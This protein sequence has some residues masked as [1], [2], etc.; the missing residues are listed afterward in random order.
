MGCARREDLDIRRFIAALAALA[1]IMATVSASP[2]VERFADWHRQNEFRAFGSSSS[3]DL[4]WWESYLLQAY[5]PVYAATGDESWLDR[6]AAH[7]DTMFAV[8]RDAPDTGDYW[9]G[10]RDGFRGWG[11]TRYD[12]ADRYQEYLVHDA[13][14]CLPVARFVR[15]VFAKPALHARYLSRARAYLDVIEQQ[16]VAKWHRHWHADRGSGEALSDFGGWRQLPLN[17]SLVFGELLLVLSDAFLSPSRGR[18]DAAVPLSFYSEV[19]DSMARLFVQSLLYRPDLDACAWKY[20]PGP[21]ARPR[22][23]DLS[24]GSLD[25]SFALAARGRGI[26][27]TDL[28]RL[29][30]T[31]A[32]VM[33]NGTHASPGFTRYVNGSGPA[34]STGNLG[35]WL[36]LADFQPRVFTLVSSAAAVP[37]PHAAGALVLAT[38][39]E[40]QPRFSGPS[41]PAA[42]AGEPLPAEP[43]L[44]TVFGRRIDLPASAAPNLR[45]CDALGRTRL[46][47]RP[48]TNHLSSLP[49]G[50]YFVGSANPRFRVVI[51]P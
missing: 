47:L 50:S 20:W 28:A 19:P 46:T 17:Q 32:V 39:A 11:T 43:A 2:W 33:W 13:Q 30:N 29:G 18:D 34:D 10:Y 42:L 16:V 5:L 36:R 1:G 26:T 9:P 45:L 38:L 24:H 49:P 48:G 44:T 15:L 21:M 41:C 4:A 6:F 22:W 12:P 51:T 23:E 3:A 8:M 31:L 7:A 27:D 14:A 37:P 25:V 40:L 35:N